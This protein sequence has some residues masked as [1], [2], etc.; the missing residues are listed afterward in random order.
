MRLVLK[1]NYLIIF[2]ASPTLPQNLKDIQTSWDNLNKNQYARLTPREGI[3]NLI[4]SE[5]R[6]E[7]L[8]FYESILSSQVRDDY[9]EAAEVAMMLLGS[10]KKFSHH[11]PAGDSNARWLCKYLYAAKNYLFKDQLKHDSNTVQHLEDFL[12][13][14]IFIYLPGWYLTPFL[15]ESTTSDLNLAK[16]LQW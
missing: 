7:L 9:R 10:K 12:L 3:H 14:S 13:F 11:P 2:A 16:D 6:K 15:T 1:N 5:K 8:N 4:P